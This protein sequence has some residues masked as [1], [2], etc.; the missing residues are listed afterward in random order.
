DE[1]GRAIEDME[2]LALKAMGATT[3]SVGLWQPQ[4]ATVT[5][6]RTGIEIPIAGSLTG[7]VFESQRAT[8]TLRRDIPKATFAVFLASDTS[9]AAAI[10][11]APLTVAGERFGVLIV[12]ADRA[13]F[14]AEHD[15]A[16]VELIAAQMALVIQSVQR[17]QAFRD[18]AEQLD[19]AN[20]HK[21]QFLASM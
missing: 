6:R 10:L 13:P 12:S 11:A 18:Q 1:A 9:R 15:L 8:Y 4:S 7:R 16:L 21:A 20:R 14:F 2:Q 19:S 5:F 3:V 17:N